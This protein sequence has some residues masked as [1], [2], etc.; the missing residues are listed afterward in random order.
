MREKRKRKEETTDYL[1][2]CEKSKGWL[3]LVGWVAGLLERGTSEFSK[4]IR[5]FVILRGVWVTCTYMY[6]E[7]H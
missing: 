3:C 5:I 1:T 4:V 7:V 2:K 6:I